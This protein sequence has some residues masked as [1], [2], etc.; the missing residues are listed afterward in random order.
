MAF[1][2][3]LCTCVPMACR[4]EGEGWE[5]VAFSHY[6][7]PWHAGRISRR[8]RREGYQRVKLSF[9]R[10]LKHGTFV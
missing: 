7:C 8:R 2:H 5:G 9:F 10:M 3:Y 1:S 4:E 6:V